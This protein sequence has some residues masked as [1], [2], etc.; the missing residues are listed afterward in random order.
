MRVSTAT[1]QGSA[2]K[3]NIGCLF[4]LFVLG[5]L[6]YIT[7][8]FLPHYVSHFELK[9]AVQE[10]AVYRATRT[11]TSEKQAIQDEV[12]GKARE[13]G[14]RL[15][16]D[17]VKVRQEGEKVHIT[18]NYTVPVELPNRVYNLNFEFTSHN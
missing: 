7:Y 6:G 2:G 11:Q 13:L 1:R 5:A 17:D 4:I 14:I 16:R 8:K 18:V 3:G 10:I 12:V 9:D 15:R